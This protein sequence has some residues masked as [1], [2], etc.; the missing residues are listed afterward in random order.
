MSLPKSFRDDDIE[1]LAGRFRLG[2]AEDSLGASV[3]KD[4]TAR[5]VGVDDRIRSVLRNGSAETIEIE[6]YGVASL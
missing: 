6:A 4:D 5:R 3:P 2:K 1:R